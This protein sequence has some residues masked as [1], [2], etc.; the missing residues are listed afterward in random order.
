LEVKDGTKMIALAVVGHQMGFVDM[1]R[2]LVSLHFC[3]CWHFWRL[4]HILTM[5]A[6]HSF[7]NILSLLTLCVLVSFFFAILCH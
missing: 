7:G 1:A 3:C 2:L 6:T 5:W 4:M